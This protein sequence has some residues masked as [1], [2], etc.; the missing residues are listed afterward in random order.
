MIV[1]H[2]HGVTDREIRASVQNGSR[3]CADVA[4]CCGAGSGCGGCASLVAEIVQ[5]ERRRLAV[6][7]SDATGSPLA[8]LPVPADQPTLKSA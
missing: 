8:H 3:S 6:L 2:C 1:C 7:K 5:S 4:S